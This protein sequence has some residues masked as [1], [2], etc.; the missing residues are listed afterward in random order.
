M[1]D[2]RTKLREMLK[3]LPKKELLFLK[4]E[5]RKEARAR[6]LAETE[7]LERKKAGFEGLRNVMAGVTWALA[8]R[9]SLRRS[10]G[11][12][13]DTGKGPQSGEM[14]L[15]REMLTA[16]RLEV[17]TRT[18]SPLGCADWT[19]VHNWLRVEAQRKKPPADGGTVQFVIPFARETAVMHLSDRVYQDMVDF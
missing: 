18:W 1:S 2:V 16:L 10:K 3:A 7:A 15:P 12:E 8:C 4:K 5:L 19:A 9:Q 14:W 11:H 17:K 6:W 13:P